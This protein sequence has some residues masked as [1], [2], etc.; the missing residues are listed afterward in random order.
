MFKRICHLSL[1]VVAL[2]VWLGASAEAAA[3][4]VRVGPP[5]PVVERVVRRPGPAYAWV[6]GYYRWAGRSYAWVPGRWALPPRPAAVWI[7]PH[8][9]YVPAR[10][11]YVFVEGFWR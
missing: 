3:I 9:D 1:A 4:Y 11:S 2:A 10:G 7:A 8:W 6:G 5:R